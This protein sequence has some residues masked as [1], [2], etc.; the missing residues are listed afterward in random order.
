LTSVGVLELVVRLFI[1][2]NPRRHTSPL[3][4]EILNYFSTFHDNYPLRTSPNVS[5]MSTN[6]IVTCA[7][8]EAVE[9][10]GVAVKVWQSPSWSLIARCIWSEFWR[11]KEEEEILMV[12]S[13]EALRIFDL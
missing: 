4:E 3:C 10:G 2:W 13:E 11:G 6:F 1:D 9:D 7:F 12:T 5:W 8:P